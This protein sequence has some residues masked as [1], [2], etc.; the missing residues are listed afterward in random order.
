MRWV[1]KKQDGNFE[2]IKSSNKPNDNAQ[3]M[4][5]LL[6]SEDEAYLVVSESTVVDEFGASKQVYNVALDLGTK[7]SIEEQK[8]I[9]KAAKEAFKTLETEILAD[10]AITAGTT[11]NT[12][13]MMDLFTYMR[14]KNNPELFDGEGLV[15]KKD[16]GNFVKGEALSTTLK[17]SQ[18]AEAMLAESDQ[19]MIRRLKKITDYII[20]G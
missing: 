14:M 8:A 18:Y 9:A 16:A 20:G 17:I 10:A 3:L 12:S 13:A 15:A 2:F 5:P 4:E 19:F 6:W 1:S 11:D 7:E